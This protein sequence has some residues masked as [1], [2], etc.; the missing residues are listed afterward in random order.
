MPEI[1]DE[2]IVEV[3]R[4]Y[5][6]APHSRAKTEVLYEGVKSIMFKLNRYTNDSEKFKEKSAIAISE[7]ESMLN[8]FYYNDKDFMEKILYEAKAYMLEISTQ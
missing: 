3:Y 2:V 6:E 5:Q 7:L 8:R 4:D 1:H